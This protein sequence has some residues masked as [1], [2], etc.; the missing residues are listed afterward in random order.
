[1]LASGAANR[2]DISATQKSKESGRFQPRLFITFSRHFT[3]FRGVLNA[4]RRRKTPSNNAS[5]ADRSTP[6]FDVD[7]WRPAPATDLAAAW[8]TP[9]RWGGGGMAGPGIWR[10]GGLAGYAENC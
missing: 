9:G 10:T 4:V 7:P 6:P 8:Q 1:M 5:T 3:P 2:C